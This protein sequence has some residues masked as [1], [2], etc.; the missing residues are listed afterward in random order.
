MVLSCFSQI[1]ECQSPSASNG[2]P[3]LKTSAKNVEQLARMPLDER[4]KERCRFVFD[5]FAAINDLEPSI[6]T[7]EAVTRVQS[8]SPLELVAVCCMLSHWGKQRPKG[9]L[10]G[11]IGLLRK[12]LREAH[13]DLRLNNMCWK[14]AWNYID[15]LE[16]HRGITEQS[17][18]QGAGPGPGKSKKKASKKSGLSAPAPASGLLPT[19][20]PVGTFQANP[21]VTDPS[22]TTHQTL[23]HEVDRN[24]YQPAFIP[25][26]KATVSQQTQQVPVLFL[27][28]QVQT[29]STPASPTP[30]PT[31]GQGFPTSG[32]SPYWAKSHQP[33]RSIPANDE[34]AQRQ[35]ILAQ[36]Q[37]VKSNNKTPS[38]STSN[39]AHPQAPVYAGSQQP[40]PTPSMNP[41]TKRKAQV[42][43]LDPDMRTSMRVKQEVS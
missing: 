6:F 17:G 40:A 30:A 14:T 39:E 33:P 32:A 19:G 4:S 20:P 7:A 41:A 27:P 16:D 11:D 43:D 2:R 28:S 1:F 24:N 10:T 12:K 34:D 18:R 38:N 42:I 22:Q 35:R 9:T 25:V 5:L 31:F 29:Q 3:I 21:R 13:S 23:A 26:N 36:F 15:N 37:G 8:F